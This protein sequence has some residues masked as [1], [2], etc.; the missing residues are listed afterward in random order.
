[1]KNIIWVISILF[2]VTL[3]GTK[4]NHTELNNPDPNAPYKIKDEIRKQ[5]GYIQKAQKKL[6]ITNNSNKNELL[7]NINTYIRAMEYQIL[8]LGRLKNELR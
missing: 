3:L 4:I 2:C 7:N 1:M 6:Q 8:N 5:F